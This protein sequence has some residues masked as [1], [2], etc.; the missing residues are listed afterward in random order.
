MSSRR[1]SFGSWRS[2]RSTRGLHRTS[3]RRGDGPPHRPPPRGASVAGVRP[4]VLDYPMADK[5][6]IFGLH[7][8]ADLTF[9]V[10]GV[11]AMIATLSDTQPK[12]GGS[13]G[14]DGQSR[15][16]AVYEKA[17]ELLE[18]LP[19]ETIVLDPQQITATDRNQKERQAEMQHQLQS[20]HPRPRQLLIQLLPW[21][22]DRNWTGKWATQQLAYKPE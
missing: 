6:E 9:R 8:N 18:K 10:K 2:T 22:Q 4:H 11:K 1:S 16:D 3:T 14:G 13:T 20:L 15:E 21:F 5:P 12:G 19:P 7:P 17:G